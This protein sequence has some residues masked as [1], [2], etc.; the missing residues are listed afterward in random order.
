VALT[1]TIAGAAGCPAGQLLRIDWAWGTAG[2]VGLL[3]LVRRPVRELLVFLMLNG[4]ATFAVLAHEGLHR[5]DVAGFITILAETTAIQLV[6][7]VA[8]RQMGATAG[9]AA[10]VTQVEAAARQDE[11]IAE[12]CE[13]PGRPAGWPCRRPPDR[14]C[15]S[16]RPG[17][18][19]PP[20]PRSAAPAGWRPPGCAA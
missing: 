13:S 8:A 7:A 11:L 1:V 17:R 20:T 16:W 5:A 2:W 15:A 6:V 19:T 14:C 18:P 9:E 3:V 12:P 10:E 4:L